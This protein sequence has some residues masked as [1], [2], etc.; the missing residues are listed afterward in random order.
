MEEEIRVLEE[1][2]NNKII[3]CGCGYTTEKAIE[4]LI[5]AYK[6]LEEEFKEL[7]HE[8]SRLEK[9]EYDKEDKY[10]VRI[11]ELEEENKRKDEIIRNLHNSLYR[12]GKYTRI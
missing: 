3:Y 5:S 2:I 7:D 11:K 10:L 12:T 8:C 6:K 4:H 9:K 1:N